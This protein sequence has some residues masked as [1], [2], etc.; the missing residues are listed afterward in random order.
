[1]SETLLEQVG[2]NGNVQ[3][4]VEQHAG[5]CYLYLHYLPEAGQEVKCVWVRNL[6]PAPLQLD[7]AAMRRGDP[8]L[9]PA[10]YCRNSEASPPLVK[11]RLHVAWLPEGNGCALYEADELLAIIPPWSGEG[12]FDGYSR[13]AIGQGPLAWELSPDNLLHHRFRQ[14]AE[15][16][17]LWDDEGLWQRTSGELIDRIEGALGRHSKYYAID[18]KAWPPRAMLRIPGRDFD[19]LVTIGVSSRP[20]PNVERYADDPCDFQRIELGVILP[21]TCPDA[22]LLKFGSYLSA[23]A[24]L[25]W[26]KYTWFGHGHTIPCDSWPNRGYD[27][28][29]LTRVH[30][31]APRIDLGRQ[32]GDLVHILWFLPITA[33]ERQFAMDNGSEVLL[34]RLPPNRWQ[35]A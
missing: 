5:T 26:S 4:C 6:L 9:N 8:P 2:P 1:M 13:E 30:P 19:T 17:K 18:G 14:A 32:F 27:S 28:A 11:D 35:S 10:Q 34:E 33:A 15:Y 22:S 31:T 16:W 25:P 20:Q 21:K 23:Q 24:M 12:G 7:L 29:I 3:A